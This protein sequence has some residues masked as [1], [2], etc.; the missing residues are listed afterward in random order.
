MIPATTVMGLYGDKWVGVIPLMIPFAIAMP[1]YGVHSLL[2]PILC[3]LGRPALEFWPQAISCALAA[4]A[5]FAAVRVSLVSV[6]WALLFIMLVRFGM[7]ALFT[8]RLLAISWSEVLVLLIKRAGF[9]I[10]FGSVIWCA[11]QAL[12]GLQLSAGHRLGILAVC[13]VALLS[14]AIWSAGNIIFGEH[15]IRFML[16]Y[17]PHLPSR[18]VSRLHL[19]ARSSLST[20]LTHS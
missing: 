15:A 12:R 9:S 10:V 18:Y 7:I 2:G 1:F 14:W 16:T 19:Q 11:D 13:C 8:F 5:Y 3:G 17:A 4:I 6:A 20:V